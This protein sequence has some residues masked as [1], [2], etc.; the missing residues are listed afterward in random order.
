MGGQ[1]LAKLE[2][3]LRRLPADYPYAVEP[4]HG[5][6]FES[7]S[8]ER[9]FD[10]L[11][12]ELAMD[13]VILDSRAL[14]SAPAEDDG[15]AEAQERKPRLPIHRRPTGLRPMVR[16]VGRNQVEPSRPWIHEWA[17]QVAQ[18]IRGGLDPY[19][20]THTPT[21]QFAP[22]MA[23]AFHLELARHVGGLADMSLWPGETEPVRSRQLPLFE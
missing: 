9:A 14:Y 7:G 11:L 17:I 2:S 12:S 20:F 4:R 13:R 1:S 16:F 18:W 22:A 15:E 8:C 10:Q 3:F 19:M 5:D 6:F 23:R 21:D